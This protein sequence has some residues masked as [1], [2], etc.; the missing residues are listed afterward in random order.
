M[1]LPEPLPPP[2]SNCGFLMWAGVLAPRGTAT[3]LDWKEMKCV[4]QGLGAGCGHASALQV[5]GKTASGLSRAC[6]FPF[7]SVP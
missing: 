4:V 3:G 6:V 2:C 5:S 7:P 1:F